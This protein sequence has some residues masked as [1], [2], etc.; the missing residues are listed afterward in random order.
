[1]NPFILLLLQES[2]VIFQRI[3]IKKEVYMYNVVSE[4]GDVYYGT[5]EACLLFIKEHPELGL[6]ED[7]IIEE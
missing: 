7:D 1:M 6:S 3:G 4:N 2:I 5:Y